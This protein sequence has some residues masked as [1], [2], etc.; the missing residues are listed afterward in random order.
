MSTLEVVLKTLTD[1]S[2]VLLIL[3]VVWRASKKLAEK[4][5]EIAELRETVVQMT[6]DR[7]EEFDH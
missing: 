1:L 3:F 6:K 4:D 5:Q 2:P 7:D